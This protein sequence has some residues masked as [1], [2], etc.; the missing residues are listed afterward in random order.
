ML[1]VTVSVKAAPPAVSD[2]GLTLE[3]TGAGVG[4]FLIVKVRAVEVP[5]PGP[6]FDT[7]TVTVPA[8][9]MYVSGINT[10]SWVALTIVGVMGV[11][12]HSTTELELKPVP[13]T[14]TVRALVLPA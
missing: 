2:A 12:F 10:V 14:V 5:P 9:V 13:V 7:F 8:V 1:P 3:I 11:V 6:G 4:V